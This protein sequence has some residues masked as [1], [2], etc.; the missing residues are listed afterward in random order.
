MV[1]R[2]KAT[3]L[4]SAF[5]GLLI[6]LLITLPQT[7]VYRSGTTLEIQGMNDNLLN[8]REVDPTAGEANSYYAP[9]TTIPTQIMLLQGETLITRVLSKLKLEQRPEA[10]EQTG[11]VSA[12]R[13]ALGLPQPKTSSSREEALAMASGNLQIRA[14]PQT[15]IIEL[16][17]D[18]I[19][20]RVAA[21]F[22]NTLANEF[23]EQSLE[24]RWK[25]AQY[26]SDWLSRQLQDLKI[27]LEKSE[28]QLQAYA[29]TVGLMFTAEKDSIDEQNLRQVQNELSTAKADR[30]A[31]QS[32]YEAASAVTAGALAEILDDASLREHQTKL[33]D[34][35]R[36][37]AELSSAFTPAFY[38]VQRVQAQ[39]AELETALEKER[40]NILTRI[41]NEYTAAERR[42]KLL[43]AEYST[44]L[45]LISDQAGKAIHYNILKREVDTNRQ[46]YEAMLQKVKE[47]GIASAFRASNIHVVDP[48]K[49][50]RLPYKPDLFRNSL[51]GLFAG[52]FLGIFFAILK[53]RSDCT[54]QVPG[55]APSFLNVPEL[56]VIQRASIESQRPVYG[57]GHPALPL[58]SGIEGQQRDEEEASV[59]RGNGHRRRNGRRDN[60]VELVTWEWELTMLAESFRTTLASIL[61]SAKNGDRPRVMVLSSCSP[62]EGKTTIVSNLGIALAE[63]NH[64]VLLIDA[65]MRKPR[66][67][68][69]YGQLNNCGLS[70]LLRERNP[71]EEYP[72][73]VLVRQTEIPGLH[74]LPSGHGA[75][76]ISNLLY[77]ARLPELL[78]RFRRE[79][80][81][82]LIDTPPMLQISDARVLGRL[83]DGVILVLFANH[84]T[85]DTALAAIQRFREDG[86]PILGT[87]L[88]HWDP[89]RSPGYGYYNSYYYHQA[90]QQNGDEKT[91]PT[92]EQ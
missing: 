63:I 2:R 5:L 31:R 11:R 28:D 18:S 66:L 78:A 72:L 87:I 55:D 76:R 75:R 30:I 74:L 90:Y 43:A 79:F 70:N 10:F 25:T 88:N 37:L 1:R 68:N 64:R 16:L 62:M 20:P 67:H 59:G 60:S 69:V 44:Q 13:K 52:I 12:W 50:S 24:S 65:D 34:L 77:S 86:T 14:L 33:I 49:P 26:T 89:K 39:I 85:R 6:S 45:K 38:K 42:E 48:A 92:T 40:A 32:R 17:C 36:Q 57:G 80:D 73:D 9:E 27:N 81:T 3:V 47:Y 29:R 35:R 19:D 15:R 71:I 41:Q 7:P 53:E 8:T 23:I 51:R 61:F 58:Q 46:L 56:G 84:T 91:A 83:A 22:A 21:D 4:V 54:I 82:I